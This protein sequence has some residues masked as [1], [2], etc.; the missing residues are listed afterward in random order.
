[1]NEIYFDNAATTPLDPQVLKE[2]LPYLTEIYGNAESEHEAGFRAKEAI[3][4]SLKEIAEVLSC[5]TSEIIFTSGGTEANNLAIFGTLK[6]SGKKH[7]IT[8]E[9][10]H[11]SILEPLKELEKSG[12]EITR[13]KVNNEGLINLN[14]LKNAI[15]PETGLV[16][17]IYANNEIGTIQR[18]QEIGKIA[19]AH[20]VPFHTD[21]CQ[22]P[23]YLPIDTKALNI[24]LMTLNGSKIYGPKGIGALYV[25]KGTPISPIIFGG[26][27]QKGLRSGTQNTPAIVGF[28][29]ALKLAHDH[30]AENSQKTEKLANFFITELKKNLPNIKLKS[31]SNNRLPNILN[32]TFPGIEGKELVFQLSAHGIYV[33]TGSACSTKKSTASHVL[34]AIGLTESEANSSIRF[35][36]GKETTIDEI[37]STLNILKVLLK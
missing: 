8:S 23:N 11:P 6:A 29:K 37:Q 22:A 32:I 18:I 28:A 4:N 25:K 2:M 19:R 24:D 7:V 33:S 20:G 1:M 26:D 5:T 12:I 3:D 14:E 21:A 35:S 16:T 36:F 34:K 31:P 10:E 13:L 30:R 17:I 27:Q 9:I 15:K